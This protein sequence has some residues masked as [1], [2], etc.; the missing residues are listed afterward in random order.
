MAAKKNTDN[1]TLKAMEGAIRAAIPNGEA[2]LS[3]TKPQGLV[4]EAIKGLKADIAPGFLGAIG[5]FTPGDIHVATKVGV[6]GVYVKGSYA[7][8]TLGAKSVLDSYTSSGEQLGEVG[9]IQEA[10]NLKDFTG[11]LAELIGEHL[12]IPESAKLKAKTP[13]RYH[14]L[15][16][17][18]QGRL[19]VAAEG[20]KEMS[21]FKL[22]AM[23]VWDLSMVPVSSVDSLRGLK[24]GPSRFKTLGGRV[25][26]M[27]LPAAGDASLAAPA[28]FLFQSEAEEL[29]AMAE[30]ESFA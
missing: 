8:L 7:Q 12:R 27:A 14:E 6:G 10:V 16:L 26:P 24:T 29:N 5:E 18:F 1:S 3:V 25:T 11:G 2:L 30:E 19:M 20:E 9:L 13:V 15:V 22:T 28:N 17:V 21:F 4:A 23:M